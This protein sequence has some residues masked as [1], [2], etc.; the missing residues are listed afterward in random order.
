M[1]LISFSL[2]E[3]TGPKEGLWPFLRESLG[4]A[5]KIAVVGVPKTIENDL[6]FVQRSFGFETSVSMAVEAVFRAYPEAIGAYNG[7]GLV[8]LMGRE[9]GFIAAQAV[10]AVMI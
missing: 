1:V 6:S 2:L 7:I 10:L 9:S 4:G 3:G 8:N 5:S